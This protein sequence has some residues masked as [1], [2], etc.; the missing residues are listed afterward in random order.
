MAKKVEYLIQPKNLAEYY[1]GTI[2]P[3]IRYLAGIE[4]AKTHFS[5]E[6]C[7]QLIVQC[8][9]LKSFL[10]G[11]LVH[12]LVDEIS[13]QEIIQT[14]FPISIIQNKLSRKQIA[15]LLELFYIKNSLC[16]P[17]IVGTYNQV[18][19]D[20]GLHEETSIRF[21]E[22]MDRYF[23]SESLD[24]KISILAELMREKNKQSVEQYISAAKH[25]QENVL[26]QNL[27]LFSIRLSRVNQKIESK[28][29][30][31]LGQSAN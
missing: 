19:N 23:T 28:L 12:C 8:P 25:L 15:V 31:S 26:L 13:L 2:T 22:L 20:I 6:K 7:R 21:S 17:K 3:D 27:L 4:R 24:L 1:W 14:A 9:D 16:K 10:Q 11:Y 18:M 5:K 30:A 29:I